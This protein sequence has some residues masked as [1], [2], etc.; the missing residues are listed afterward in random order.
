M[1]SPETPAIRCDVAVVGAGPVGLAAAIGLRRAGLSVVLVERGG[2]PAAHALARHDAKVYAIAP[3]SARLLALLGV[4]ERI[5]ATRTS[6]YTAMRV[7]D[8]EPARAL[9]FAAADAGAAQL[10]WIVEHGLIVSALW[11]RREGIE[12]LLNARVESLRLP[13]GAGRE[14]AQITLADG[15]GIDAKLVV[16]ADGADSQI[17]ELAGIETVGWRY[18]QRALVCEI[19]TERPHRGIAQQRFLATGPLA[20]L[21]LSDGRCSIVW[22]AEE[23][24]A[25]ELLALDDAAF[26]ARLTEA[27]QGVLG[28]ILDAGPRLAVP[29]RLLHAR[30]YV[31]EG[32]A[33]VG[34]AAHAIHPLAGQGLNLGLADVA[35]L[36]ATIVAAREAGRDWR[37]GRRLAHYAR[38][39]KAANLEMLALT[40]GLSRAFGLRLPGLKTALGLGLE[41]VDRLAPLKELLMRQAASA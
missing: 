26:R 29:L 17:R 7:W 24:L 27:S 38:A 35:Q 21:P 11:A 14:L 10:G 36:L 8:R 32:L 16:A 19:G 6:P 33:L 5:A 34:D 2:A 40:D 37:S 9:T 1:I 3:E 28:E 31:R 39:R 13:D 4:W 18:G 12:V 20:L 25:S 30:E 23:A 41:A 15:R 22:S